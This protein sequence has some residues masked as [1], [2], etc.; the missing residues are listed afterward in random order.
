MPFMIARYTLIII[1]EV[2]FEQIFTLTYFIRMKCD[3][4]IKFL[5]AI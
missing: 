4:V 5:C 1:V 2:S 3:Y